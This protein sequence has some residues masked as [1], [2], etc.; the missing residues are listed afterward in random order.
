MTQIET[1]IKNMTNTNKATVL[2]MIVNV[3]GSAYRKEG[4]WM[5]FTE[6]ESPVGIISGGCLENDLHKRA[7]KLF[8]TG[9]T[10]L[11]SYDMSSEDDL[12]WGRGAGCNGVVYVLLRDVD[13]SFRTALSRVRQALQN[14]EPVLYIQSTDDLTHYTFT[15]KNTDSNGFWDEDVDWEWIGIQPFQEVVGE[16]KF[17]TSRYFIQLIWPKTDLYILGAGVDA[18]PLAKFAHEVGFDVHLLDWRENFCQEKYFPEALS[19]RHQNFTTLLD[20]M[21]FSPLDAVVIMTHDF[22]YDLKLLSTLKDKQ[23]LYLG[24]LG[25]QKR[26]ERL[27]GE[28]IP[29]K[30]RTPVG[31]SIGADGPEEIAISIVAELIAVK[32]RK[33][34]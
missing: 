28:K 18:R 21:T 30:I 20:D 3:E 22:Q 10:E 25:S 14:K 15:N 33:I 8:H 2:A 12:G 24:V 9:K 26:T 7:K 27:L 17:G 29:N 5:L 31:F 11:I 32:R 19:V 1:L 16:R 34:I 23:L 6:G 13:Q 4:A